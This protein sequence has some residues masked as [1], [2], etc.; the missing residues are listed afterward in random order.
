MSERTAEQIAEE[1]LAKAKGKTNGKTPPH[2][3]RGEGAALLDDVSAFLKRFIA[4][5]CT[6]ALDGFVGID[7]AHCVPFARAWIGKDALDGGV[8]IAG[9]GSGGG[10]ERHASILVQKMRQRG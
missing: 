10:G 7:T 2:V 1:A 8:R 6:Y 9:A 3:E 5:P 4:Y